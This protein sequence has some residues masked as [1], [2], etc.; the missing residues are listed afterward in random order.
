MAFLDGTAVNV[1]LPVLGRDLHAGFAG[2]QWVLNGYLVALASLVLTGGSLGDRW[3]RRR[4]FVVG[5]SGFALTSILC[6][7]A[8]NLNVLV[9]ARV[10]Q[11]I[12]A[13]LLVP[14]SLALI[15]VEFHGDDRG[16]AVGLWSGLSGITTLA[17]P[18]LGGWLA[19]D[20]SWRAIFVLNVPLAVGAVWLALAAVPSRP[21]SGRRGPV[22]SQ[23]AV[24]AVGMLGGSVFALTQGPEWG[25]THPAVLAAGALAAVAGLGFL[26][27]E[28]NHPAPMLPPRYLRQRPFLG[29]N[30]VT[31]GVYFALSGLLFL[32]AIQLQRVAHY[33]AFQAGAATAPITLLLL[34]F[35][36]AA[37][38]LA[39]RGGPEPFLVAGPLVAA[40]GALLLGSMGPRADYP[41]EVLPGVL[42]F[43][44]GLS[45]TVAPVTGAALNALDEA[46]AG[47]ASGVNNAV[48][49]TA[50]LLAVPLLPL[51][52][53]ISG[54]DR[55][56]GVAFDEGFHSACRWA[57]AALVATA[58]LSAG[59][60]GLRPGAAGFDSA[61]S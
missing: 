14:T 44:V 61:T 33:T 42:V 10:L 59:V 49:R 37:G 17:G 31:L 39:G 5:A 54:I 4:S 28:R 3:G 24:M 41:S 19:D 2:F 8:P 1:A 32:L 56:G 34:L 38:R 27:A 11:G 30:M 55:V 52:A 36:P 25:W 53:G 12:T 40:V 45:L 57:A 51:V 50:Q 48:A 7:A 20:V 16:R 18:L 9:A 60:L 13:A 23:G 47:V 58:L 6:A 29:A 21:G 43:G 15:Q 26:D 22:D 35:S 46:R